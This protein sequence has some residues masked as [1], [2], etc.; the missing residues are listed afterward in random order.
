MKAKNEFTSLTYH[1]LHKVISVI[2]MCTWLRIF[3]KNGVY[4]KVLSE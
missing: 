2:I 4:K 1:V 3:L